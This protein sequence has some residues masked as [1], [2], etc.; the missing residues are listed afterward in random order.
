MRRHR[1][2]AR[3]IDVEPQAPT[4]AMTAR[5]TIMA[6]PF[7]AAIVAAG[8]SPPA[9]AAV[10]AGAP[11][12]ANIAVL[13]ADPNSLSRTA[14]SAMIG[15]K[16]GVD[17]STPGTPARTAM[18]KLGDGRYRRVL[19]EL[20]GIASGV[21]ARVIIQSALAEASGTASAEL[22]LPEGDWMIASAADGPIADASAIKV[23]ASNVVIRGAGIGKTR[24]V[25]SIARNIV[26][27]MGTAGSRLTNVSIS[28]MTLE[29]NGLAS[30]QRGVSAHYAENLRLDRLLIKNMGNNGINVFYSNGAILQDV[31]VT[32]CRD[33]GILFYR[34]AHAK[35]LDVYIHDLG[36]GRA[37]LG[38][39]F[40]SSQYCLAVRPRIA[41]VQGYGF[42]AWDDELDLVNYRDQGHMLENASISDSRVGGTFNA[43]GVYISKT[44]G[45]NIQGGRFV[46]SATGLISCNAATD[47]TISGIS[48][49]TGAHGA[50]ALSIQGASSFRVSDVSANGRGNSNEIGF[51]VSG[52]PIYGS[53]RNSQFINGAAGRS[54]GDFAAARLES[55]VSGVFVE[56]NDFSDYQIVKTQRRGMYD[57]SVAGVNYWRN[58]K[59][60]GNTTTNKFLPARSIDSGNITT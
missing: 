29:G 47:L 33:F 11:T 25:S 34:S 48:E 15:A 58:N 10:E 1:D 26:G 32:G 60:V 50:P 46:N 41:R 2:K 4:P 49:L 18:V 42:Y 52:R 13:L 16:V 21:D 14:L 8:A 12:D 30:N 53:L 31:E 57:R 55:T 3:S 36:Q 37:H 44:R 28:D 35:V 23:T 51:L 22:V 45:M 56:N 38:L 54:V 20:R 27:V 5:R 7:V 39:Q 59:S 19:S 9:A 24:L 17:I 43:Q 6:A 40:K